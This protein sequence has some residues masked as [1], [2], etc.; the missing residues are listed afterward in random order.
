MRKI[1]VESEGVAELLVNNLVGWLNKLGNF[2][3]MGLDMEI[4]VCIK[5]SFT[6]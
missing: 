5:Q 1:V 6:C 3:R 4:S 2:G